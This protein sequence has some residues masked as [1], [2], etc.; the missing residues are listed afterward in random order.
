MNQGKMEV[1]VTAQ[2]E[3][4]MQAKELLDDLEVLNKKY[5]IQTSITICPQVNVEAFYKRPQ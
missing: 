3:T 4:F 5:D 2:V 1:I